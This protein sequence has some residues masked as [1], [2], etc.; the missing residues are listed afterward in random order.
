MSGTSK[1]PAIGFLTAVEHDEFGIFGGYL[2]LNASGRP[3]E[4][5]CTQP[6]KASKAQQILYGPTLR[7]CLFEQIGPA[8][9][10]KGKAAPRLICTD[11]LQLLSSRAAASVPLILVLGDGEEEAVGSASSFHLGK[12][13]VAVSEDRAS[14]QATIDDIWRQNFGGQLDLREPFGR[15]R[16]ALE[17]AQRAIRPAA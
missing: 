2:I 10:S 3:L 16:E 5:H 15:I 14:E 8:L 6:I 11:Q 17:E 1:P 4:F 9:L 7:D 13:S 12:Q